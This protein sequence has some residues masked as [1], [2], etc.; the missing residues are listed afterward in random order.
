MLKLR[1]CRFLLMGPDEIKEQLGNQAATGD[2]ATVIKPSQGNLGEV[3][4][5][6]EAP[7]G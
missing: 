5:I 1:K 7:A 6:K 3:P 4:S 2:D